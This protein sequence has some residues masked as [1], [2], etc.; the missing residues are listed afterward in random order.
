MVAT[1]NIKAGEILV[2]ANF[3]FLFPLRKIIAIC[4]TIHWQ[5]KHNSTDP[6]FKPY[7]DSLPKLAKLLFV[8]NREKIQRW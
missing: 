4:Q 7:L 3:S 1:D 6:F 8:E 2:Q 5:K